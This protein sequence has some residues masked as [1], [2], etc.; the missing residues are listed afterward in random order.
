[1]IVFNF[2]TDCVVSVAV[3]I[4]SFISGA[5]IVH[6]VIGVILSLI[7]S[8]FNVSTLFFVLRVVFVLMVVDLPLSLVFLL[9]FH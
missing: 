1:M 5:I 2:S 3:D 8:L 9:L 6:V 4:V 7:A